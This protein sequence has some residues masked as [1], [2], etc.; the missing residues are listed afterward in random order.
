MKYLDDLPKRH[1]NHIIESKAVVAFE[2]IIDESECFMIQQKDTQDYG[3]DCQLEV[4]NDGNATNI[5]IHVQLKGTKKALNKDGSISIDINRSNLNYLISQQYSFFVCYHIPTN[6][7]KFCYA[8]TV[9]RQYEH[10]Q[11]RWT[12]Q[13]T[14]TVNFTDFLT[15]QRLESLAKLAKANSNELRNSRI[16]QITTSPTEM[17][18]TIKTI[19]F[20]LYIPEDQKNAT[21]LLSTLYNSGEDKIISD[22]FDRFLALFP[23]DHNAIIYCYMAEINIGMAQKEIDLIRVKSGINYLES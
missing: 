17:V 22:N 2:K 11:Q 14:I 10:S 1:P 8:D 6:S 20:D 13:Q 12:T 23:S 15:I 21:T 3:T 7:L 5:R 9:L 16:K 4:V 18:S 19:P